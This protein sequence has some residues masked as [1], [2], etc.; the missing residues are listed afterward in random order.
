MLDLHEERTYTVPSN[1]IAIHTG[2][3]GGPYEELGQVKVRKGAQPT[4][5]NKRPTEADLEPKLRAKAEK[6]GADAII[7]VQ[8]VAGVIPS[9]W[10][11]LTAT[12]TAVKLK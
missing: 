1:G 6:M 3:P 4:P 2:E 11:G 9:S 5:F 8:Y 10:K 12:G 7:N